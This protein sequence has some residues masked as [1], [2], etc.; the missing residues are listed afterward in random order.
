MYPP[1]PSIK[2]PTLFAITTTLLTLTSGIPFT[3]S[4]GIPLVVSP[5]LNVSTNP[6]APSHLPC[7]NLTSAPQ[8]QCYTSLNTTSYLTNFNLTKAEVCSPAQPWTTC[9]LNSVYQ[10][11]GTNCTRVSVDTEICVPFDCVTFGS[12]T[13]VQPTVS[14]RTDITVIE[15][16][17][18]YAAWNVYEVH[19]H[20]MAWATAINQTSS[21]RAILAAINPRVSNTAAS[22]LETLI[23]NYGFN[24]NAD[25]AIVQ[26]LKTQAADNSTAEPSYGNSRLRGEV[27]T[28]SGTQWRSVLVGRLQSMLVTVSAYN[29]YDGWIGLVKGNAYSTR[30][31]SGAEALAG[32]LK[33]VGSGY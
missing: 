13:C 22:V 3:L 17:G 11:P 18:W 2:M 33:K 32:S 27:S 29:G 26:L 24:P 28:L 19:Q 20:V 1:P 7:T 8:I 4:S 14:N 25:K 16:Q 9:L 23:G 21:E 31:L 6:N 15:A 30:G 5:G 10:S 12:T